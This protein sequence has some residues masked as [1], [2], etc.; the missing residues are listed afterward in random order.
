[1]A[2]RI[3]M[4]LS[5]L[6][7]AVG[8]GFFAWQGMAPPP[9]VLSSRSDEAPPPPAPRARL[10]VAARPLAAGTLLKD[11][12][13]S[14]RE[15]APGELP[16]GAL[17]QS[18]ADLQEMRGAMLR[19]F[20]DPGQTLTRADL[21]QPR[22]RGFLAA[23]LNPGM[24]AVSMGVDVVTG[25]A[26][27]IWPGDRVDVILSQEVAIEAAP[28][29]RR[30]MAETLVEGL[31]VLAVDQQIIRGAIDPNHPE[32]RVGRT[33]TLEMPPEQAERLAVAIRLGRLTLAVRPLEVGPPQARSLGP[34]VFSGDVSTA[35][36]RSP[37]APGTVMRVIQGEESQEVSFR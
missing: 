11:D 21:M 31:R 30:V 4:G 33:I 6:L 29:A 22:E 15:G 20:L 32:N 35:L 34:A 27:L 12:D 36:S 17:T 18:E 25:T 13:V 5:L 37:T 16:P 23:V 19:R 2:L 1:M 3:L 8:L 26:G 9:P 28:L 14:S 10:L 7:A 24:R